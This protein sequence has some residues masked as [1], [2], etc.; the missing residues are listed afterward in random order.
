M[1]SSIPFV[2]RVE[3]R[4]PARGGVDGEDIENAKVRGPIRCAPGG[5]A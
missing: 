4:R 5:A 3:N 1:K 2:A